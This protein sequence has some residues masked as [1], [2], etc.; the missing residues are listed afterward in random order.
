MIEEQHADDRAGRGAGPG[1][2]CALDRAPARRDPVVDLADAQLHRRRSAGRPAPVVQ[3]RYSRT[4]TEVQRQALRRAAPSV[5]RRRTGAPC[6]AGRRVAGDDARRSSSST[7]VSRRSCRRTCSSSADRRRRRSRRRHVGKRDRAHEQMRLA[8]SRQPRPSTMR[9]RRVLGA[10]AAGCRAIGEQS[11][12]PVAIDPGRHARRRIDMRPRAGHRRG[13]GRRSRAADRAAA[14]LLAHARSAGTS[15]NETPGELARRRRLPL[16]EDARDIAAAG[17]LNLERR[18]LR[19]STRARSLSARRRLWTRYE[20]KLKNSS[21]PPS[22]KNATIRIAGT[23]PM[24][25]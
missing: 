25:M 1:R 8:G 18:R 2:S 19:R 17:A 4:L 16:R 3:S 23:N 10:R 5:G 15:A 22:R 24:K 21:R 14:R 11:A 12:E 6:E 13:R 9:G 20:L 7:P